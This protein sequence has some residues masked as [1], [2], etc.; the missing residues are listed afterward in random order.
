MTRTAPLFF[1]ALIA[2]GSLFTVT[3]RGETCE[4]VFFSSDIKSSVAL[5]SPDL[6]VE[7]V[8][9]VPTTRGWRWIH[10]SLFSLTVTPVRDWY[11]VDGYLS[12]VRAVDTLSTK[13]QSSKGREFA[14]EALS[15]EGRRTTALTSD[16]VE[17][18]RK[19][20]ETESPVRRTA[21]TFRDARTHQIVSF[22]GLYWGGLHPAN[23]RNEA[24]KDHLLPW[25]RAFLSEEHQSRIAANSQARFEL[26]RLAKDPSTELIDLP[27]IGPFISEYLLMSGV[28]TGPIFVHTGPLQARRYRSL[29]FTIH[30][31]PRENQ[32]I[33][34]QSVESFISRY[35]PY[36][37]RDRNPLP[38]RVISFM[39]EN[40]YE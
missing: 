18:L 12:G 38:L 32:Y 23:M 35:P 9:Y 34:M 15:N 22:L 5:L 40:F 27:T 37:F 25:E 19:S 29:G 6:E 20:D 7:R 10:S 36:A 16:F 14:Y 2:S 3:A 13:E 4:Q 8:G 1:C 17:G 26:N 28:T 33:L 39:G 11:H 30:A 31:Q 24:Q 21:F